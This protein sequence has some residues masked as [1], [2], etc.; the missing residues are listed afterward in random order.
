MGA[1]VLA[2]MLLGA[3]SMAEITTERTILLQLLV[4][5]KVKAPKILVLISA[6]FA[7]NPF[8]PV[9]EKVK[10][11]VSGPFALMSGDTK[12][13]SPAQMTVGVGI[14]IE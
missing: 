2:L 13:E 8:G 14:V 1:L 9:Q 5:L 11:S 10:G 7:V 4:A 6:V 3:V 12:K